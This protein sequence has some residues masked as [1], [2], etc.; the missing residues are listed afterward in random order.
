M[1][2]QVT[3]IKQLNIPRDLLR[4]LDTTLTVKLLSSCVHISV[5]RVRKEIQPEILRPLELD[6]WRRRELNAMSELLRVVEKH[7]PHLQVMFIEL[8]PFLGGRSFF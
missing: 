6:A 3:S 4:K 5:L 8:D 1:L 2:E 7:C